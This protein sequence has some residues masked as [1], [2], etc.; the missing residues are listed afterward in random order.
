MLAGAAQKAC[1]IKCL[2]YQLLVC[3]SIQAEGCSVL[4]SSQLS[5]VCELPI[6]GQNTQDQTTLNWLFCDA[7]LG[8][9]L[10]HQ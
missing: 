3:N 2:I 1:A 9:T 5:N 6:L 10:S 4:W 8:H 7:G